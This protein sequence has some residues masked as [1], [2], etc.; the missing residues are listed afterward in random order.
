MYNVLKP[1]FLFIVENMAE[2][3]NVEAR[4]AMLGND[5]RREGKKVPQY[6]ATI[7]G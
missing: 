4:T 6:L 2:D 7:A 5:S 3:N 1:L